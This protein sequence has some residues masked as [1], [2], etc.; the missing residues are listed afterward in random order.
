MQVLNDKFLISSPKKWEEDQ[1]LILNNKTLIDYRF[2]IES[3]GVENRFLTLFAGERKSIQLGNKRQT[4]ASITP[5][6][7]PGQTINFKISEKPYAIPE[8]K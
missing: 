2:M 4:Q 6:S 8:T 5:M 7:P 1:H 3:D